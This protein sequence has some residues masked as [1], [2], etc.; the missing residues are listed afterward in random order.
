M[1][2]KTSEKIFFAIIHWIPIAW[3]IFITKKYALLYDILFIKKF[4]RN[5]EYNRSL[6]LCRLGK[7]VG[8]IKN[9]VSWIFIAKLK[10]YAKNTKG[11]KEVHIC[12]TAPKRVKKTTVPILPHPTLRKAEKHFIKPITTNN[13]KKTNLTFPRESH[14]ENRAVARHCKRQRKKCKT[15]TTF[16]GVQSL[17][18]SSLLPIRKY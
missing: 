2:S 8:S 9:L 6:K 18:A 16:P 13:Y 5:N 17:L 15:P 1:T 11:Q 12:T 3:P 7:N 4:S 10:N 14:A